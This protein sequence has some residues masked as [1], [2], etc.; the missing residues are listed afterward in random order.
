MDGAQVW[1]RKISGQDEALPEIEV[2]STVTIFLNFL[3]Y[4]SP[5]PILSRQELLALLA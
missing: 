3:T 5:D 1:N 4:P 2:M